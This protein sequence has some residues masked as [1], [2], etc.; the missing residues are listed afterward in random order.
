MLRRGIVL[1]GY[2]WRLPIDRDTSNLY[3]RQGWSSSFDLFV[4]EMS[5]AQFALRLVAI[6]RGCDPTRMILCVWCLP[7]SSAMPKPIVPCLG[8]SDARNRGCRA[9]LHRE[10]ALV[11]VVLLIFNW[12]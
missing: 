11:H 9:L 1:G 6:S 10:F 3:L 4:P 12:A 5:V 8:Y 2:A 7:L